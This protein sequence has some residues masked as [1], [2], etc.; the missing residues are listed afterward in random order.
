[1]KSNLTKQELIDWINF[2]YND[3]KQFHVLIGGFYFTFNQL[4]DFYDKFISLTRR[5]RRLNDEMNINTHLASKEA[6]EARLSRLRD[7]NKSLKRE[8]DFITTKINAISKHNEHIQLQVTQDEFEYVVNR[9]DYLE[10]EVEHFHDFLLEE[11]ELVEKGD[12][13]SFFLFIQD[14]LSDVKA[15]LKEEKPMVTK[16]VVVDEDK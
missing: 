12:E 16:I 15:Q 11:V 9:L 7:K 4:D 13:D 8:A 6:V 14:L 5:S 1:M 10:G 2:L 3:L